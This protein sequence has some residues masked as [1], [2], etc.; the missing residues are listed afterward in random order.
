V[1]FAAGLACLSSLLV[2]D[3]V[4]VLS[5]AS[6]AASAWD[7][8]I[9][10][11]SLSEARA[12]FNCFSEY[13]EIHHPPYASSSVGGVI[14]NVIPSRTCR[15]LLRSSCHT[16]ALSADWLNSSLMK[17]RQLLLAKSSFKSLR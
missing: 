15:S 2:Q 13:T 11:I 6:F 10:F 8:L 7:I 14:S 9:R 12:R 4:F 17:C 1:S 3:E 16:T 5:R